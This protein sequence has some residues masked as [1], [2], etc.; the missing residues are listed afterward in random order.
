MESKTFC[1]LPLCN[2]FQFATIFTIQNPNLQQF[3]IFCCFAISAALNSQVQENKQKNEVF[4]ENVPEKCEYFHF[5]ERGYVWRGGL[6]SGSLQHTLCAA[7]G[8]P[9]PGYCPAHGTHHG[10]RSQLSAC[11]RADRVLV[12][13]E[14]CCSEGLSYGKSQV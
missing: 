4:C 8:T 6:P 3:L 1:F 13:L 12:P 14:G 2:Y 11:L 7:A 5:R 9:R 10:T